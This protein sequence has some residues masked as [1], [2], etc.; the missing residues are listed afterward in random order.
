MREKDRFDRQLAAGALLRL[1]PGRVWEWLGAW[2]AFSRETQRA[3]VREILLR[4]EEE[5]SR[6][7]E[8]LTRLSEAEDKKIRSM[9]RAFDALIEPLR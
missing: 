3:M 1:G 5:V 9:A 8:T 2:T 7:R 4:P 6:L